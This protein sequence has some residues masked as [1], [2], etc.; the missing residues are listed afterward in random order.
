LQAILETTVDG[1][2]TIDEMGIILSFNAAAERIFGYRAS[3]VI[4]RNV[5]LLMPAPHRDRHP[6][7]IRHYLET[8]EKKIIGIGRET[9]GLRKDRTVFPIDLAV[10][11]VQV[12]SQRLFTGLLRDITERKQ[13]EQALQD[14]RNFVSAILDTVSALIM[15]M[16]TEGRIVRFNR[17]CEQVTGFSLPEVK[18]RF[19]WDVL[20]PPDDA[21]EA[22]ARFEDL[23]AGRAGVRHENSIRT[24]SGHRRRIAWSSTIMTDK[25]ANQVAY[26]IGTGLD[27]T[28][29][30]RA[31][32]A[33]VSASESERQ[34]IGRELHDALGQQLTGISLL[35][36]AIERRHAAD[37]DNQDAMELARLAQDAVKEVK[38]LARGLYP[39][40]L[41][42]HGLSEALRGLA[43][44]QER[45]TR[46]TCRFEGTDELPDIDRST[47]LHLYRIAQEA[48]NNALRHGNPTQ[49]TIRLFPVGSYVSLLIEDD[50]AGI[51]EDAASGDGM[52][53][54]IMR[55][56]A[57]MMGAIFVVE[58]RAP[59]GTRVGCTMPKP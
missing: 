44:T 14:E 57:Q 32:E 31:E 51:G 56:R 25:T 35:A 36:R 5:S 1:V 59:R 18:G 46:V 28:E 53:L 6:A 55:Y 9:E 38:E 4:G 3:E 16:D 26:V 15:V 41:E 8:G 29:R 49:V 27:V 22:R 43:R 54:A 20:L 34:V 10:S 45:L 11:E 42:K 30:R 33:L 48:T 2:V 12:G 13:F 7:Y 19:Y 50:G 39:T 52:G 58:R 21:A 40:E 23:T 17:A 24:K 37:G 47:A